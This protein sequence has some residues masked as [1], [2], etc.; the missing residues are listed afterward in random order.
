MSGFI[1]FAEPFWLL[2]GIVVLVLLVVFFNRM[3]QRRQQELAR[4]RQRQRL[5]PT[6]N[7]AQRVVQLLER[8]GDRL[9][10]QGIELG[11][12]GGAQKR[13]ENLGHFP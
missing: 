8:A 1:T 4:F 6:Q 12:L 7:T 13:A 11:I 10:V 5:P 3:Q 9:A 2:A